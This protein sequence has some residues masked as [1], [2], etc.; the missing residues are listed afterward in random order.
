MKVGHY[1][2]GP[3]LRCD[4][5]ELDSTFFVPAFF[6]LSNFVPH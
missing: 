4:V 5:T 6:T 3:L 2:M 1:I